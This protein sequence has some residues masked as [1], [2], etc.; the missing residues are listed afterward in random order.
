MQEMIRRFLTTFHA[1]SPTELEQ[2][3]DAAAGMA[4]YINLLRQVRTEAACFSRL[5]P[6]QADAQAAAAFGEPLVCA[7]AA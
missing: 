3:V 7:E 4:T 1:R 5:Q 6:W 2:P